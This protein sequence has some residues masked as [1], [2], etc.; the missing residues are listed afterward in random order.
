MEASKGTWRP[1]T[2]HGRLSRRSDLPDSVF[3]FP[4]QRK[5]PLTDGN[6]VRNAVARFDQVENA[7]D[8]DRDL[9]WSNI[10][11]AAGYYGV[12]LGEGDWRELAGPGRTN[13]PGRS[14]A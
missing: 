8:A 4:A 13:D 14:A 9:A 5:E 7:S 3:A 1:H 6:H 2:E 12:E 11:K 10:R